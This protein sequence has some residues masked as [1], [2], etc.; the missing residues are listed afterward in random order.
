MLP[1]MFINYQHHLPSRQLYMASMVLVSLFAR[2]LC[3]VRSGQVRT[4]FIA[5]FVIF[6]IH[7]LWYKKDPQ[8]EERASSTTRLIQELRQHPPSRVLLI[9]FP[10]PQI[11]IARAAALAAPGWRADLIEYARKDSECAACLILRWDPKS[12]RYSYE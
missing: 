3:E 1:Y 2:L 9:D 7:Y 6:N 4:A 8:F 10:Y 5:G 11:E 12:R